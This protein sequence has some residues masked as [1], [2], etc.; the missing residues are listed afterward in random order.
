MAIR[1]PK[2]GKQVVYYDCDVKAVTSTLDP[3]DTFYFYK[4][5]YVGTLRMSCKDGQVGISFE[6]DKDMLNKIWEEDKEI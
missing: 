3:D 5:K 1:D 2:Y 6:L 4:R